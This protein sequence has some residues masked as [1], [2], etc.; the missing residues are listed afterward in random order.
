MRKTVFSGLV[1]VLIAATAFTIAS[2]QGGGPRGRGG[3]GG[4][5]FG[6][7]GFGAWARFADLSDTQRQQIKAIVDEDRASRQ[8]PPAAMTLHRQLE[9]ELLADNP[10]DQKIETLRQ[11]LVQAQGE[12]VA[13]QI[14]LQRKIAAVLTAEQRAKVR[15]RLAE[16]PHRGPER[17]ESR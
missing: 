9:A 4:P 10:D 2:A 8:G 13:H 6:G 17:G 14:T 1:A 5:G 12:E 15:E 16:G 7:P 3:P 11:Q